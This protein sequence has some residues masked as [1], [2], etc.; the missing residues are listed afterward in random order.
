MYSLHRQDDKKGSPPE[1]TAGGV[2]N[3]SKTGVDQ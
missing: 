2:L 3:S 1:V